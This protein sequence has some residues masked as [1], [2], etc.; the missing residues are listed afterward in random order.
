MK[1]SILNFNKQFEFEP[2]IK[3]EEHLSDFDHVILCGMGGSHLGAD[4][5]KIIK[6][7]IDVYVHKDYD[8]PP[9]SEDFFKRALLIACSFSGNTEEVLSFFDLAVSKNY[10]IAVISKGGKLLEEAKKNF[11]PYI[12]IPDSNIQPRYAVGYLTLSLLKLIGDDDTISRLSLL[13][14]KLKPETLKNEAEKIAKEITN[15]VPVIYASNKN[16]HIAYNWKIKFNE[17]AK[18][19]A[20]Y[21][22][23]PELNHNEIQGFDSDSDFA[24]LFHLIFIEDDNDSEDIK[25]RMKITKEIL[26]EKG[27]SNSTLFLNFKTIEE[28]VFNSILIADWIALKLADL[29]GKDPESVPII[30]DFKNRMI[31]ND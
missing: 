20:F 10:K 7:G 26:A 6:P 1:E 13:S 31:N 8:L 3:N 14:E 9:Y 5:V 17:T 12:E 28:K 27:I 2:E 18:I 4:L 22:V 16:L 15:K 23:F 21:N 30:E 19:P 11:I 29:S 25:K 24:R